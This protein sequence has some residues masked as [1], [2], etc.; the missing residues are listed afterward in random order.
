MYSLTRQSCFQ[1][2]ESNGQPATLCLVSTKRVPEPLMN[3]DAPENLFEA[4]PALSTTH[5]SIS[6][7]QMLETRLWTNY[8]TGVAAMFYICAVLY[9]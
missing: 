1:T 4:Q 9:F 2:W 8:R 7:T 3:P 6:A 5:K